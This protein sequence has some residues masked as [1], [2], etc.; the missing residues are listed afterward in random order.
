MFLTARPGLPEDLQGALAFIQKLYQVPSADRGDLLKLWSQVLLES[1]CSC[2]VVE[3][4]DRDEGGRITAMG[5]MFCVPEEVMSYALR[6]APPFVWRW[7]LQRW[8]QGQK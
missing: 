7:T 1:E 4:T 3:D 2:H 6:E 5:F 8:R